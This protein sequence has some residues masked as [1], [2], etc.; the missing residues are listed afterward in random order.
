MCQPGTQYVTKCLM[1]GWCIAAWQSA[2]MFIFWS[3]SD[4]FTLAIPQGTCCTW[5]WSF[6]WTDLFLLLTS[7]HD[8]DWL[9]RRQLASHS[10]TAHHTW[11]TQVLIKFC[12]NALHASSHSS[13]NEVLFFGNRLDYL[14]HSCSPL[15]CKVVVLTF[16][17]IKDIFFGPLY[18]LNKDEVINWRKYNKWYIL[19][20]LI[21][22]G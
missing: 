19:Q 14:H 5:P 6:E 17:D 16:F 20:S 12:S 22:E 7:R 18:E 9:I 21:H 2:E 4:L 8:E 13:L 1:D 3:Q 15:S 11:I 10:F